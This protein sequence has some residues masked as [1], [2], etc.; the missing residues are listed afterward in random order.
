MINSSW[1]EF[2][3]SFFVD[4]NGTTVRSTG[5]TFTKISGKMGNASASRTWVLCAD[6]EMETFLFLWLCSW[7]HYQLRTTDRFTTYI[8]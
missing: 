4:F 5:E 7:S 6:V 3:L 8:D 2:N 1:T